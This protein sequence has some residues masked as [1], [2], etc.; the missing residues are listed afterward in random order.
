MWARALP[1]FRHALQTGKRVRTETAISQGTTSFAYAAVTVARGDD[2]AG[3]RGAGSLSW[4]RATWVWAC[5][6]PCRKSPRPTPRARS[7]WSTVRWRGPR[8]S[9]AKCPRAP[10]P[11]EP[12]PSTTSRPVGRGQRHPHRRGCRGACAAVADFAS[13]DRPLLVVDLGVPRNVDPKSAPAPA[14]RCSTWTR[15]RRGGKS[16]GRPAEESVAAARSSPPRSSAIARPAAS[17]CGA[18]HHIAA[19]AVEPLRVAELE[20]HRAQFAEFSGQSGGRGRGHARRSGQVLHEPTVL[21]KETAG[22]PQGERLVEAL[23]VFF[24]L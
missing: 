8:T 18:D 1:L 4:A 13:V 10:A 11:C 2:G 7:S 9:W 22:T 21:L 3:L 17:A 24:D 23:R 5:A 15:A 19:G 12:S 16:P 6:A 14:S 20:R